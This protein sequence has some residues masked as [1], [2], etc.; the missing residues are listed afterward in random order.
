MPTF[1]ITDVSPNVRDWNSQQG[2][3]MQLVERLE[4]ERA[5]KAIADSGQLG[6]FGEAA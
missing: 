3:P 6:L 4:A 5:R 2:G 1:T